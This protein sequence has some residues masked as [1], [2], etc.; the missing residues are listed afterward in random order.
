[1]S[2]KDMPVHH[3]ARVISTLMNDWNA[4]LTRNQ[5]RNLIGRHG[6]ILERAVT[7]N[8]EG[9]PLQT[10]HRN[11]PRASSRIN[12]NQSLDKLQVRL[13]A[14]ST[15]PRQTMNNI[16]KSV[17]CHVVPLVPSAPR[18]GRVSFKKSQI[19]I[20]ERYFVSLNCLVSNL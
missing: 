20:C 16:L 14:G 4:D 2:L 13:L 9:K 3:V 5:T 12:D 18:A 7:E 19:K 6:R 8:Q 11:Q 1:M 10:F 17:N 15:P